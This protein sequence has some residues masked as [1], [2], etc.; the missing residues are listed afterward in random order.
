[1]NDLSDIAPFLR[2]IVNK[3]QPSSKKIIDGIGTVQS[4]GNPNIEELI[5]RL[6]INI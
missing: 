1:M 4:Y 6:L 5:K 2:K 3:K